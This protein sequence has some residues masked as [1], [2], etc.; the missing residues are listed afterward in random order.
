MKYIITVLAF[1]FIC[2]DS[3]SQ[4]KSIKQIEQEKSSE[5]TAQITKL[6]DQVKTL[7]LNLSGVSKDNQGLLKDEFLSYREKV[8][9]VRYNESAEK[10]II[11][12]FG[13]LTIN[14]ITTILGHYGLD[15]SV[16]VSNE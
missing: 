16:I 9:T 4:S 10:M 12:H 11:V 1:V 2:L 14:K 5:R 13:S 8:V 6:D 15:S 7:T 3:Y